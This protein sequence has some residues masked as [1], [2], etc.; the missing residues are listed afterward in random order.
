MAKGPYMPNIEPI[1]A[2]GLDPK[3][4]LPTRL[5]S[6]DGSTLQNDIKRS[7]RILDEQNAVRRYRWV[8]LPNGLTSELME[9]ILY[10]K[11]QAAF[12]Y[13]KEN[14]KFYFLPYALDGTI[15]VYG[16]Y[17]DITPLP[18][19]GQPGTEKDGKIKPWISGLKRHVLY[20]MPEDYNLKDFEEGCVL[21][22]DYTQQ[23]SENIIPRQIIQDPILN[24]MSESFPMART[25]LLANSGI[26]A[27]RVNDDDQSAEVKR[28]S[29][30]VTKAALTGDPWVPMVG[31]LEFQDLTSNGSALKA[32]EYLLYLQALDNYRLSLYGLKNGGLFQKKSHMLESEQQMNDGNTTLAYIDG[33]AHRQG[34]CDLV[35]SVWPLGIACL[36]EETVMGYDMN[37]DGMIGNNEDQSGTQPGEQDAMTNEEVQE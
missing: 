33:L 14:N 4:G 30:S 13:M 17:T 31:N 6:V 16:R 11:G 20:E 25:S 23:M 26:K 8:N 15:D 29:K 27:L 12:F 9:R 19:N 10:Y 28:A 2:A 36:P 1:I 3:T 22:H 18:F 37:G 24:A 35:N 34:F 7:L 5:G 32:E 21:L